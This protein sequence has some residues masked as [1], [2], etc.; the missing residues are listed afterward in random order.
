MHYMSTVEGCGKAFK[1]A[2][3]FDQFLLA[4]IESS[5]DE[6]QELLDRELVREINSKEQKTNSIMPTSYVNCWT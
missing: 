2:A 1:N 3:I 5:N 4:A 6:I